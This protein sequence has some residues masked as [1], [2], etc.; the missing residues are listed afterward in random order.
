LVAIALGAAATLAGAL[1]MAGS[2]SADLSGGC[3]FSSANNGTPDC[4][5]ALSGSTFA[6]GDGNM[7]ANLPNGNPNP[8]GTTD[9]ENVHGQ[10]VGVDRPSGSGDNSFGG[11]TKEDNTSVTVTN[12][13]IPPN[14][15]DLTR[16]YEASEFVNNQNFLYL[17]WQRTTPLGSANLDFELNQHPTP[18]F[19]NAF[20]PS[21]SCPLTLVRTAGD[22]LI[23]FLFQNGGGRPTIQFKRWLTSGTCFTASKHPPCWGDNTVLTA[24]TD[25]IAAV[26][27]LDAITDPLRPLNSTPG[28]DQNP[29]PALDFGE[30]AI[31]LT[32]A[33]VFPAGTCEA[34]G[35]AFVKAR[36][37]NSFTAE[38]KDFIAPIPIGISNCLHLSV[39][40]NDNERTGNLLTPWQ[41]TV[42][43]FVGCNQTDPATGQSSACPTFLKPT[44]HVVYDG[45]ALLFTNTSAQVGSPQDITLSNVNVTIG[46]CVFHPWDS[47]G[48]PLTI[49]P[50]TTTTPGTMILTQT[51]FRTGANAGPWG[52][53]GCNTLSHPSGTTTPFNFDT[54]ETEP[55]MPSPFPACPS[56]TLVPTV[57]YNDGTQSLTAPNPAETLN[58]GGIDSGT[59]GCGTQNET[60]AF[61]PLN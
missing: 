32:A 9:W 58:T 60:R 55:A 50:G 39:G 59:A 18:G 27:N 29:V 12:G 40:Y 4:L 54:S 48:S 33:G 42:D 57:A 53:G 7:L 23:S 2:A 1:V 22:I 49:P 5:P 41:G 8:F 46:N 35:S 44:P 30:V 17:A 38:L 61:F 11:G 51:G 45:G 15:D 3:D 16:F 28:F 36:S 43:N 31:N 47:L 37:S 10:S 13:T 26:N 6:G 25:K 20:C 19:N 34:F 24:G 14:K 21:G 52:T 56:D